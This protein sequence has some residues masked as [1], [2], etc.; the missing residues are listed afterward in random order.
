VT[1]RRLTA[2]VVSALVLVTGAA[3]A[4]GQLQTRQ[5]GIELIPGDRAGRLVLANTGDAP[6]SAQVRVYEW[7]Q[8]EGEDQL[9]ASNSLSATPAI[10]EIPA[11]GEQLVRVVRPDASI[12]TKEQTYR[13]VVDELPGDP[14]T[15]A[16]SAIVVRMRYLVPVFVRAA[17]AAPA[18]LACSIA[19][20]T[21]TCDNSGGRAAQI[22]AATWHAP[23]GRKVELSNGL[24]GYVLAGSRRVF[25]LHP[26]QP[27]NADGGTLELQLNGQPA[28]IP[29]SP[30]R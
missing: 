17:D 3:H 9:A 27:I 18:Q 5:T 8:A 15:A 22:T 11:G 10:V 30:T 13:V 24:V 25:D 12:T 19:A 2:A 7:T 6:V 21:L 14:G 28:R 16:G 29:L 20:S 4:R 26:K 1:S 23:D